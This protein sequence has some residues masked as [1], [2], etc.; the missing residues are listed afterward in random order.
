MATDEYPPFVPMPSL[1]NELGVMFGF[2]SLC[3]VVMG[4]YVALWRSEL[5]SHSPL[6]HIP[7]SLYRFKDL[8][9]CPWLFISNTYIHLQSHFRTNS[10]VIKPY[11]TLLT[12]DPRIP[13]PPRRSRPRPPQIPSQQKPNTTT[14]R[15]NNLRNSRP[16]P[17]SQQRHHYLKNQS[18]R[19]RKDARLHQHAREPRRA[20]SPRDGDV[21]T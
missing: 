15:N 14:P 18:K 8:H 10:I 13:N 2:F 5:S 20:T 19:A 9:I 16:K 3:I 6:H 21:C 12:I 7:L 4:A 1:R 17:K 11:M